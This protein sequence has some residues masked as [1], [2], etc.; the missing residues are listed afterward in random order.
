MGGDAK[1]S[2]TVMGGGWFCGGK[3]TIFFELWN[4]GGCGYAMMRGW[5]WVHGV[6]KKKF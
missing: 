5:G 2:W 6:G 3:D 4:Y 1:V